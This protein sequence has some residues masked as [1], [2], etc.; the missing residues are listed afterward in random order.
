MSRLVQD[1]V[2]NPQLLLFFLT[3]LT[4]YVATPHS[5]LWVDS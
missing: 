5:V 2:S 1:F 3:D 4:L